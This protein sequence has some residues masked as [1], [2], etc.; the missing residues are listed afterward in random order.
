LRMLL[1]LP[2]LFLFVR[3]KGLVLSACIAGKVRYPY[4][5]A[6]RRFYAGDI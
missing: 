6:K 3:T 2:P 5:I 4:P 1:P